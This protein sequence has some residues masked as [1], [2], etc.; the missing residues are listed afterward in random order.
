MK[1]LTHFHKLET[2]EYFKVHEF[3][4]KRLRI[5]QG[6]LQKVS[7]RLTKTNDWRVDWNTHDSKFHCSCQTEIHALNI[8]FSRM[9]NLCLWKREFLSLHF[10]PPDTFFFWHLCFFSLRYLCFFPAKKVTLGRSEAILAKKASF[11]RR[12]KNTTPLLRCQNPSDARIPQM[13]ES[14]RIWC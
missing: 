10:F 14:L 6:P 3:S 8:Y 9:L 11:H 1:K 12:K 5:V 4:S 13:S 7:H 2:N